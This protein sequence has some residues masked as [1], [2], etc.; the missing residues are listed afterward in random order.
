MSEFRLRP[1]AVSDL[2]SIWN[3]TLETWG[4]DQAERYLRMIN[5]GFSELAEN[6][7]CGRECNDIREG[8]WKYR[9]GRHLIFYRQESYG[10]DV[11]RVLHQSM[12]VD[13][14]L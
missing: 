7:E 1:K 13:R 3:Y 8:Y 4:E 14:H 2:D 6:P 5:S 11:V 12:D 9:V 10:V